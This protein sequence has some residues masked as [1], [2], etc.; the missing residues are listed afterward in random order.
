MRVD[1]SKVTKQGVPI[2]KE[3]WL[4]A[5]KSLEHITPILF[6]A[7]LPEIKQDKLETEQELFQVLK[8]ATHALTYV[9]EFCAENLLFG[10]EES[11]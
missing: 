2:P 7:L 3:A 5:A 11:T 9:G 1:I 6:R 4:S 8:L 10:K